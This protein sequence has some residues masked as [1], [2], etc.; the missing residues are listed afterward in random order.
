MHDNGIIVFHDIHL[1][2]GNKQSAYATK[3]IFD[4]CVGQKLMARALSR[5]N[6]LPNIGAL[7]IG[8][9]IQKYIK[10]CFQLFSMKWEYQIKDSEFKIYYDFF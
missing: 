6:M 8:N 2:F 9:N 4:S 5:S 1:H 3:L 10:D 7:I